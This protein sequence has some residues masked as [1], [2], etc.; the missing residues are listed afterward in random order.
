MDKWKKIFKGWAGVPVLILLALVAIWSVNSLFPVLRSRFE[1]WQVRRAYE[2]LAEPYYK[3]TY[4]GKTPEETYDLF[5]SAL[6]KGDTDLA[7]K[8]FV[9]EKQESWTKTLYEY[10]KAGT[11]ANFVSELEN[12]RK[13]W[14]KSSKSTE[15]S[16]SFKYRV[17][18]EEGT[19]ATIDGQEVEIPS[20]KYVNE[21]IFNKY[22]SMVW[23][24][25]VL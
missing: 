19:K 18:I 5:I 20:G 10:K 1:S 25:S 7:S 17:V 2:K 21:S 11:M 3:D 15:T 6:K 4:G 12:T 24:I 9:I 8:Y 16:A 22:P 14:T 23:K 13:I